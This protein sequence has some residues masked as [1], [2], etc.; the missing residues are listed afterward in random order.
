MT[1]M[2]IIAG[3][4]AAGGTFWGLFCLPLL[5]GGDWAHLNR[6][7]LSILAGYLVTI[8]YFI[9][10]CSKHPSLFTRR[11]IWILSALVQGG[12]LGW[13]IWGA[14]HGGARANDFVFAGWWLFAFTAS[15]VGLFAD[16]HVTSA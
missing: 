3:I 14:V 15:L 9:R 7:D 16:S 2:R 6:T 12:W 13:Y 11:T 1:P 5:I 4:L 8:G 10:C